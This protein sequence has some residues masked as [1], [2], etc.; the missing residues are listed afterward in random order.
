M[1]LRSYSENRNKNFQIQGGANVPPPVSA[2][3]FTSTDF[4]YK[5]EKCI[6]IRLKI[7]AIENI[8]LL[9]N[10]LFKN[11]SYNKNIYD[12]N[13]ILILRPVSWTHDGFLPLVLVAESASF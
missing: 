13:L 2:P 5:F 10:M 12:F 6:F 11:K 8:F 4:T 7:L 3:G 9:L 1:L